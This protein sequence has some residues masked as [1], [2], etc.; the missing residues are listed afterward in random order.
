MN[1]CIRATSNRLLLTV[2]LAVIAA[3]AACSPEKTATLARVR[4]TPGCFSPDSIYM[5]VRA[6]LSPDGHHLPF[7]GGL[8]ARTI[9]QGRGRDS[10]ALWAIV[11]ESVP[12]ARPISRR[13]YIRSNAFLG[14]V[15]DGPVLVFAADSTRGSR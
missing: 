4:A 14:L 12:V 5:V 1:G 6:T 9:W 8:V 2:V 10:V 11:P 7:S 13:F 3:S 15:F